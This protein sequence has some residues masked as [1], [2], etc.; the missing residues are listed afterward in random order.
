MPR[1]FR[2]ATETLGKMEKRIE[3]DLD[4]IRNWSVYPDLWIILRTMVLVL[5]DHNAY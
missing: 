1:V 4:Y 3:Y 2:S 5:K